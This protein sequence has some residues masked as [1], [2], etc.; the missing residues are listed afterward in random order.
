MTM[1]TKLLF[2][3]AVLAATPSFAQQPVYGHVGSDTAGSVAMLVKYIGTTGSAT[4]DIAVAAGGDMSF[5][6][7]GQADTSVNTT[8]TID[9]STPPA[10]NDT[11][12]EVVDLI[13]ASTNW[14]AV[15]VGAL[16][17]DSSDNTLTT[18]AVTAAQKAEGVPL[19]FDSAVSLTTSIALIPENCKT[20]I[21]CFL[22]PAGKLL[23]NPS[24]G[25]QTEV[26]WVEGYST[27]A[28]TGTF[29]IYSVK[30]SNKTGTGAETVT[31]I[32][33]EVTG[34]SGTNKQL[35]QFE[36]VGLKG[37]ANEKVIV[38]ITDTGAS[39]AFFLHAYGHQV[40]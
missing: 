10:G 21:R 39:S 6:V 36:N 22:T 1:K 34:A 19:Y 25:T 3:L 13:N 4:T 28:T 18:F 27:Y 12:G 2:A 31:T 7:A 38:R 37:R 35:T 26:K 23:E 33:S 5:R 8:G 17:S 16:R 20:D 29:N 14:R 32:W 15:L 9:C 30:P 24:G 40:K 11:L